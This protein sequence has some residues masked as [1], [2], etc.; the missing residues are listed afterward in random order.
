MT[1]DFD[2]AG[3]LPA[4]KKELDAAAARVQQAAA[5]RD[6]AAREFEEAHRRWS[7]LHGLYRSVRDLTD[8]PTP[9]EE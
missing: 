2:P 3:M 8:T 6:A 1:D 9:E 4:I 7:T 5:A